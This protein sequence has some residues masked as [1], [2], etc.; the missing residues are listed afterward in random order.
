MTSTPA[1][2]RAWRVAITSDVGR[3]DGALVERAGA[4]LDLVACPVL[5]EAPPEDVS[6]LAAV[7][8]RLET[9]DWVLC[10][11]VRAVGA[12][13]RLHPAPWPAG[14]RSA[15][16]GTV[17]AAALT[18]F[19]AT[20]PPLTTAVPGADALWAAI[21]PLGPWSARRV[22]VLTTPGGRTTLADQLRAAG[23]HVDI[24]EAYRMEPRPLDEIRRDWHAAAPDAVIIG[25][26]RAAQTLAE[27]IGRAGLARLEAVVAIGPTTGEAVTALGIPC[28]VSPSATFAAAV[29]TMA[30]LR[31]EG[32]PA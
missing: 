1:P 25:S 14:V 10:A 18:E 28:V 24:V 20:P 29:E 31:A 16:V 26:P 13:R 32:T 30:R 15:A 7:S 23:A 8:V 21:E 3:L 6:G 4:A 19:G 11:S 5:V 12:L 2:H 22:L 27:A 17:T 9:Y